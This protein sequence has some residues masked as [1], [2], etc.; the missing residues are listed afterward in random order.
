MLEKP[1]PL[2]PSTHNSIWVKE[3]NRRWLRLELD[4]IVYVTA[5]NNNI[6]IHTASRVY[7]EIGVNMRNF[8]QQVSHPALVRVH[9]SYLVNLDHLRMMEDNTLYLS[10]VKVPIGESY[11]KELFE[12][13]HFLRNA[14]E[15]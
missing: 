13:L 9:R 8:T 2:I 1:G 5:E 6:N 12:Q 10:K 4:D 3:K 11:R 15:E 14:I 7:R